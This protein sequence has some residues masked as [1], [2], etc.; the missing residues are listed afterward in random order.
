MKKRNEVII[1]AIVLFFAFNLLIY[2]IYCY[3]NKESFVVKDTKYKTYVISLNNNKGK[4][5]YEKIKEFLDSNL[6]YYEK[7]DAVNGK[8]FKTINDICKSEGYED[9]KCMNRG[10]SRDSHLGATG[11][12]LSHLKCLKLISEGKYPYGLILE[13]DAIFIGDKIKDIEKIVNKNFDFVWLVSTIIPDKIKFKDEVPSEGTEALLVSKNFATKLY[14]LLKP[15]SAWLDLNE[16]IN[17]CTVKHGCIYDWVL[18]CAVKNLT[19]NYKWIPLFTQDPIEDSQV[20]ESQFVY[21]PSTKNNSILELD[22]V[23]IPKTAGTAI[24]N[25]ANEKGVKWG[26]LKDIKSIKNCSH[27]HDPDEIIN[28]NKTLFTVV[29]DPYSRMVSNYNCPW[30]NKDC[31]N[32][33]KEMNKWI[34]ENLEKLK[35]SPFIL[36]CHLVP[37][38]NY[39]YNE[40]KRRIKHIIKYENLDQEFRDLMELYKLEIKLEKKQNTKICNLTVDNLY[41]ETKELIYKMYSK[42]FLAFGYLP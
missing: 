28:L 42:D 27:H 14:N 9:L 12:Y 25:A 38:Y 35:E 8:S 10:K 4:K 18:P 22:F 26:Y 6:V 21:T 41:P 13:D 37:Q 2:G 39:V 40:E 29:R 7:I 11:C 3:C 16:T 34:V 30:V 31:K 17:C 20:S 1:L 15:G 32:D 23:H 19:T 24:E 5:K 36:D 33:P